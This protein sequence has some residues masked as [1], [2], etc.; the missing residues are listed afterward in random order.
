VTFF[1]LHFLGLSG[2]PRRIVDFPD[3]YQGWNMVATLGS[4]ISLIATVLFF[5][6]VY[7]MFAYG[8]AGRNAPYATK[9]LTQMQLIELLSNMKLSKKHINY[10]FLVFLDVP[11]N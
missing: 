6:V 1:P 11:K 4:S 3:F 2:M 8:K 7:D 10:L 9:L 5:Y